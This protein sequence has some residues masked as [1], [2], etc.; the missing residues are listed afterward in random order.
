MTAKIDIHID[1]ICTI[2]THCSPVS[3]PVCPLLHSAL[4]PPAHKS[5]HVGFILGEIG[6]EL[7]WVE[8]DTPTPT[9]L[10]R[11]YSYITLRLW[12][13]SVAAMKIFRA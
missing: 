10:A 5:C 7:G 1:T 11:T 6:G 2:H 12:T 13:V 3:D 4:A 9:H 8:P